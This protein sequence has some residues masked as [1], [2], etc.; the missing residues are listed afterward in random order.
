MVR[1]NAIHI[2]RGTKKGT[3]FSWTPKLHQCL[4]ITRNHKNLIDIKKEASPNHP[5]NLALHNKPVEN[6][7]IPK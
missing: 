2:D 3:N 7:T 1:F 6:S 5:L 4:L